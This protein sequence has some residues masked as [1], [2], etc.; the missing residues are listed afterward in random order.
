MGEPHWSLNRNLPAPHFRP[1]PHSPLGA[2]TLYPQSTPPSFPTHSRTVSFGTQQLPHVLLAAREKRRPNTPAR[3]VAGAH[4]CS[5]SR[6]GTLQYL[7]S[8]LILPNQVAQMA[9][10]YEPSCF[11]IKSALLRLGRH[12]IVAE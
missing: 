9:Y 10:W 7:I 4:S 8:C 5:I 1:P 11:F 3:V 2:H 6:S 12:S